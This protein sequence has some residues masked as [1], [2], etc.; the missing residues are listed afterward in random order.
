MDYDTNNT[1]NNQETGNDN[2]IPEGIDR[3]A[4][5][6][7]RD[8]MKAKFPVIVEKYLEN[9]TNYIAQ[10]EEAFASGDARALANAVH[11]L[12]SS[13][14]SLGVTAVS[15]IA[16][17]IEHRADNVAEN[18]GDL[19]VLEPLLDNLK[20]ARNAVEKMLRQEAQ[21]AGAV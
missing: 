11:P 3:E 15:G 21:N 13:S 5:E 9:S 17:E 20:N 7:L 8:L 19:S 1:T 4:L 14:A 6:K 10:A 16:R 12:K 2:T 18:G